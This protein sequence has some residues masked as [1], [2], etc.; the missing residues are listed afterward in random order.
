MGRSSAALFARSLVART[1]ARRPA[2][3]GGSPSAP[4]LMP[5][6]AVP[7]RAH[8]EPG[9]PPGA[10]AQNGAAEQT[11]AAAQFRQ[12]ERA[13]QPESR[14]REHVPVAEPNPVAPAVEPKSSAK[15]G[16]T[17]KDNKPQKPEVH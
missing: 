12:G 6:Q 11:G 8:R 2:V 5:A 10:P 1:N 9:P 17:P 7:L 13:V 14:S 4:N 16:S 15:S 3:I